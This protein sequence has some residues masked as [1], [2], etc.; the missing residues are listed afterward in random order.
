MTSQQGIFHKGSRIGVLFI[1]GLTGTPKEMDSLGLRLHK[2]GFTVSIPVLA[3][4]CGNVEDL[5]ATGRAAWAKG[6]EEEYHKLVET[7]DV[8]FVG[9]LSA[10]ASMSILLA[11]KYPEIRGMSLYSTTLKCNGWSVSK[12]SV[13]LPLLLKIPMFRRN[14]RFAEAYPY[15]IKNELLRERIVMKLESGDSS[16]A[17][18]TNTPGMILHEMLCIADE[19]K[20]VMPKTKT[21]ALIVHAEEDDLANISNA[22]YVHAHL[23]GKTD[24]LYLHD[25]YHLVVIDQERQKVADATARFFYEQLSEQEREKLVSAA[26][27]SIPTKKPGA[28]ENF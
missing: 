20:K 21:P 2:Y 13:F 4:H 19:A 18:N 24:L 5:M 14:Y 25:S 8:V 1:H 16:A 12:M 7:T 26:R 3:G 10:G 28:A 22:R 6:I 23:G 11:N 15:G 17:G 9:G 27:K